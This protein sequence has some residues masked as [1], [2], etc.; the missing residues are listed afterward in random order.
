ML[1]K[2][3]LGLTLVGLLALPLV[4]SAA[5]VDGKVT[6]EVAGKVTGVDRAD[7]SFV[8]ADGTRLWVSDTEL[9]DMQQGDQVRA[10]YDVRDGKKI[11]TRIERRT[12]TGGQET[13]NFGG[14]VDG[15][16]FDR[17]ESPDGE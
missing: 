2:K 15:Q 4:V 5:E 7:H 13:T 1:M 10:A 16:S 6:G 17:L 14:R 11:V 3:F 8:L 9:A 12:V